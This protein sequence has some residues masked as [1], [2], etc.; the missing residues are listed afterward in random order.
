MLFFH[1][2]SNLIYI[3]F[4]ILKS[5]RLSQQFLSHL[6]IVKF[7]FG[8]QDILGL[9]VQKIGFH[10]YVICHKAHFN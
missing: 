5:I 3:R 4:K 8:Q 9:E 1:A 7:L 10:P 2:S 6:S